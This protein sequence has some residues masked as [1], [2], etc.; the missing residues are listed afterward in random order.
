MRICLASS[1]GGHLTEALEIGN[2]INGEKFFITFPS[3]HLRETFRDKEYYV[4]ID[5]RRNPIR[6]MKAF[7][8]TLKLLWQKRPDVVIS[9]GAGV[10]IPICYLGKIFGAKIVYVECGC[11]VTEPSMGARIIYPIADMFVVRWKPLL[12]YFKNAEYGESL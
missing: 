5:P 11:R 12:K 10:T 6:L 3:P 4:I 2:G 8:Q 9:T 1:A 7:L